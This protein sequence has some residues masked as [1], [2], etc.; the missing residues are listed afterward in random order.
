MPVHNGEVEGTV[1]ELLDGR[2]VIGNSG[3]LQKPAAAETKSEK[4]A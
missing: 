3:L 4:N 2:N 1:P